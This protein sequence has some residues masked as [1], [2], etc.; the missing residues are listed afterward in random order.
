MTDPARTRVVWWTSVITGITSC[1]VSAMILPKKVSGPIAQLLIDGR[2]DLAS[3]KFLGFLRGHVVGVDIA[4]GD[5]DG[6][7]LIVVVIDGAAV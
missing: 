7:L 4:D 2:Y 3:Y 6:G 5:I 1:L